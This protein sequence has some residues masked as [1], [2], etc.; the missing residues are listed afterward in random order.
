MHIYICVYIYVISNVAVSSMA[1]K[2][3]VFDEAPPPEHASVSS[4]LQHRRS[5]APEEA[6]TAFFGANLQT[7][8]PG[9]GLG[10]IQHFEHH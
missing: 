7:N 3:Q 10:I 8:Q 2:S 5:V 1:S 6:D 9:S 4:E